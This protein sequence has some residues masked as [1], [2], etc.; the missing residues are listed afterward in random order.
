VRAINVL[1]V[2]DDILEQEFLYSIIQEELPNGTQLLTCISGTQAVE[3]ARQVLPS[4]IF[5]DIIIPEIDGIQAIQEIRKFLPDACITILSASS[6]FSCARKAIGLHVFDYLLK[7]VKPSAIKQ[8]Y[9]KMLSSVNNSKTNSEDT[10]IE[11]K[12]GMPSFV[13]ESIKYIKENYCE[14]LTLQ[15]VSSH[16]FMNPQYFSRIFKKEIGVT[17]TDYVNNLKILHACKLLET[18]SYAAYRISSECGFSDQS[19][20]N[21]VFF[22]HTKMTPKEYQKKTFM[23]RQK[24]ESVSSKE[25]ASE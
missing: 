21:R 3:I 13:E 5:M 25:I 9:Q 22:N 20:F 14:K 23:N 18:T 10:K 19:Y 2:E 15:Q 17:Y 24:R 4:I 8:I 1:I 12:L 11:E 6:D 16:V 7:P